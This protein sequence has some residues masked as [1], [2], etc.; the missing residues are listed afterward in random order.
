MPELKIDETALGRVAASGLREALRGI[1]WLQG[2][3]AYLPAD[4]VMKRCA[5]SAKRTL[6]GLR[7]TMTPTAARGWD[8]FAELYEDVAALVALANKE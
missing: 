1:L 2:A 3:K 4:E 6:E 5:E 8:S 7:R